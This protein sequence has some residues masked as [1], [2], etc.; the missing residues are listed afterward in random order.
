MTATLPQ[1]A[2]IRDWAARYV[3]RGWPVLLLVQDSSGG[4][5]PP[6]MC[7]AC[8]PS[9]T[10][11]RH[12]PEGC[13]HL[14]CHG[15]YAAT[16]DM[17]RFDQMRARLP[18]GKLAIRTGQVS[19]LLVIDVEAENL[20]ALDRWEELT[21]GTSLPPTLTARSVSGGVHL[22]YRL[23][24][25]SRT[26]RNGAV[27]EG[28]D[29]KS[30]AG[31]V[32]AVGGQDGRTWLGA[33]LDTPVAEL[34]SETLAWLAQTRRRGYGRGSPA[35]GGSP[36]ADYDF[37]AFWRDGCPDGQRDYFINDLCFRLRK[38]DTPYDRYV[39]AVRA[40]W[41][42]VA[43]PPL[44]RHYMP[45]EHAEYKAERVW[46]EVTPNP[47]VATN[48]VERSRTTP[49]GSH[50]TPNG[51]EPPPPAP[52]DED[53]AAAW[54]PGEGPSESGNAERLARLARD[55]LLHVAGLGWYVWT[56]QTWRPDELNDALH[57][58]LEV[59]RDI[60]EEVLTLPEDDRAPLVRW[61]GRSESVA[62]R[63]GTLVAAA[64]H[65]RLRAGIADMDRDPWLLVVR[66]GTLDLRTG[67]LRASDP[68][69]R[70]TQVADVAYDPDARCPAW[71]EH[72]A[73]VSRHKDGSPDPA[74]ER[75]HA[76]WAGYTLTGLVTEQRFL[77]AHGEG[78]NGKNALIETLLGLLGTYGMKGSAKLLLGSGAEHET[79][80]ADLAG[81]RMVF[82]DE[83]PR[84]RINESRLKELTGSGRLRARKIAQDSF[85]FDVRAKLWVSGNRKPRIADT[86]LGFWRRLALVPF[87]TPIPV[88]RRVK[89]YVRVLAAEWPGILNWALEGLAEYREVGLAEP[90][91]VAGAGADYREDENT[92]GQFVAETFDPEAPETTWRW[93]PNNV[94]HALYA[95]WCAGNGDHRP[96]TM[97][98]LRQD[99]SHHGFLRDPKPRKV[100]AGW[101][102]RTVTSR[103]Y[104]APPVVGEL[105]V[106]LTWSETGAV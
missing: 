38:R 4:K 96:A 6:A 74:L 65:P 31:Y 68:A 20:D 3:A 71:L 99:W 25:G 97:Q 26:V 7:D 103:G 30:D 21:G 101:L 86:S 66:N 52:S 57:R 98:Q 23:P 80:I 95:R 100:S 105:D 69:D 75:Y 42:R 36:G 10:V 44:A 77:F 59:V 61:A 37:E 82:V 70:N 29:V 106:T 1:P 56:G 55:R 81:A 33:G 51:A 28:V 87:D 72:V 89:D 60:R 11:P 49:N 91:R 27:A 92:F 62:V 73:L 35:G 53:V 14:L 67:A 24:P 78:D 83:T 76:R 63:R 46:Q 94:L 90:D 5:I 48:W 13:D 9:E 45:W 41:E 17:A 102:G 79:V 54:S 88:E 43:Q 34:P 2:E 16:L 39:L 85:E 15:V 12:D 93:T 58:T 22:Y 8:R 84:G 32:G 64:S 40:A 18:D 47:P 50:P 104:I 19:Q